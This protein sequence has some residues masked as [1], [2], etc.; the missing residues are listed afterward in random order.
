VGEGTRILDIQIHSV[1]DGS[2]NPLPINTSG[3]VASAFA[4]RFAQGGSDTDLARL[5]DAWPKLP[6]LIRRAILA[7]VESAG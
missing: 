4:R 2:R 7:L 3:E 5:L 6:L 1:E